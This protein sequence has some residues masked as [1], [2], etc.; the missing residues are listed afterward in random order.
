MR[1]MKIKIDEEGVIVQFAPEKRTRKVL[2]AR[3]ASGPLDYSHGLDSDN[4]VGKA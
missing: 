2:R 4:T 1:E 3:Q